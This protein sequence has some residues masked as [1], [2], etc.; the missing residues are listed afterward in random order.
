MK[1]IPVIYRPEALDDIDAIFLYVLEA[2]QHFLTA[3]KFSDRLV[4]RCEKIGNAPFGGATRS[5]LGPDLRI[6]PFEDKAVIL[7]RVLENAVEVTNIF[8]RGRDYDA[9]MANKT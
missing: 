2:S 1:P 3:R 8:Y 6:V 4:E 7:Y 5:D 9:I